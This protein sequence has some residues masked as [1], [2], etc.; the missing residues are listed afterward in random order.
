M[1]N[2]EITVLYHAHCPDGLAAAYACWEQFGAAAQYLPVSY[3]QVLPEI[4]VDH[5]VYI[6]DFSYPPDVMRRLALERLPLGKPDPWVILLDHH[7][8][9]ERDLLALD[10]EGI[11]GLG[12][13]FDLEES[14][15]SLTWKYLQSPREHLEAA[16][17]LFFRYV[18]D[19]DLWRWQL[20]DSQAIAQAYRLIQDPPEWERLR[21][22]A[23]D[24]ETVRGYDTIVDQGYAMLR[25]AKMLVQEQAARAATATIGGHVVPVVNATTLFSEVGEALCL[26]YPEAPFAAYWFDRADGNRQ[27]GLRSRGGFDCSLVA[28]Q[29]GGG[30]HPGA[31]GFTTEQTWKGEAQP[32]EGPGL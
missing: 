6:V 3:G 31:G 4:P 16:L 21:E 32:S 18:R 5:T 17:P 25:Y 22:F 24:L 30:G 2:L 20:P 14:G 8:G 12:I 1:S 27:W 11:P 10:D 15:A 19:R 7:A 28:K 26:R 29:Y 13:T 9:A 23:Q